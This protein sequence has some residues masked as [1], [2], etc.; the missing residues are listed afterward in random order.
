MKEDEIDKLLDG[1]D[2][3][4][5]R[6]SASY[7]RPEA[8]QVFDDP[9][10]SLDDDNGLVSAKKIQSTQET[11][12]LSVETKIAMFV[13]AF[14]YLLC[15]LCTTFCYKFCYKGQSD[16]D[17]KEEDID[18]KKKKFK[19]AKAALSLDEVKES[20]ELKEQS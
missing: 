7:E 14:F 17:E 2:L 16:Q 3:P 4:D 18:L 13:I 11:G 5:T 19:L 6:V 10:T 20:S 12:G 8:E 1:S 9:F 15:G